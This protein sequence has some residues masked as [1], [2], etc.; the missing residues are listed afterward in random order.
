M[1][2]IKLKSTGQKIAGGI[3]DE[4]HAR[5]ILDELDVNFDDVDIIFSPDEILMSRQLSYSKYTDSEL[6][7]FMS[8]LLIPELIAMMPEERQ[9]ILQ[10]IFDEV[11]SKRTTIKKTYPKQG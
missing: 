9:L 7:H 4:V 6:N 8:E 11:V 10:P 2:I 5:S 1:A 3:L